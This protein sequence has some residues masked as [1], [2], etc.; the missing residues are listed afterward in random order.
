MSQQ[1]N[2]FFLFVLTSM[3]RHRIPS[4]TLPPHPAFLSPLAL[5][6]CDKTKK[7]IS[8]TVWKTILALKYFYEH[9]EQD[10]HL[11]STAE[12][13]SH[14][15]FNLQLKRTL[16]DTVPGLPYCLSFFEVFH[17][18]I[19][20]RN[21]TRSHKISLDISRGRL[22]R[23]YLKDL[24]L[25]NMVV[26]PRALAIG[27]NHVQLANA[28][29]IDQIPGFAEFES[30]M[31]LHSSLLPLSISASCL[32]IHLIM[33]AINYPSSDSL[34][35]S[36][37][38][39]GATPISHSPPSVIMPHELSV[40]YRLLSDNPNSLLAHLNIDAA[41]KIINDV[42]IYD[43]QLQMLRLES[44]PDFQDMQRLFSTDAS[45]QDP[46]A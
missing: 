38:P 37:T 15:M 22:T 25:L 14:Y 29:Q 41:L 34:S 2:S 39:I 16:H 19:S 13:G 3:I 8:F 24:K 12:S 1:S 40:L 6:L 26:L 20:L 21:K 27:F 31:R 5:D 23:S 11:L 45:S 7:K 32:A 18:I 4:L 30:F 43:S 36:S 17:N 42:L 9:H 35:L 33:P 10:Y 46:C 28:A 44:D